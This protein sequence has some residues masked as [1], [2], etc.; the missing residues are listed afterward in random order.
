MP[1]MD[2][3]AATKAI[4]VYEKKNKLEPV[5]IIALSAHAYPEHTQRCLSSGMN[6]NIEKPIRKKE[7]LAA[8]LQC[9]S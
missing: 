3:Y 8:L 4:R 9:D 7:L 5:K 1:I 2:G 6:S